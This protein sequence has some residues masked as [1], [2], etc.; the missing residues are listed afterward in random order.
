MAER[1]TGAAT[2]QVEFEAPPWRYELLYFGSSEFVITG[3]WL[4]VSNSSGRLERSEF[5]PSG[6][7]PGGVF[8]W[9]KPVTGSE[10]ANHLVRLAQDTLIRCT[11]A[12]GHVA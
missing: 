6:S 7:D 11:D 5:L 1:P 4:G 10:C 12:A 2:L 9:L 8:A 3:W